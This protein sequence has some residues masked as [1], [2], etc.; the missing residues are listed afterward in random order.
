MLEGR[1]YSVKDLANITQESSGIVEEVLEFL[2]KYGFIER[3]GSN[4]PVYARSKIGIS[5][6]ESISLLKSLVTSIA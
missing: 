3:I 1:Y 4:V 6:G 2:T 5:P